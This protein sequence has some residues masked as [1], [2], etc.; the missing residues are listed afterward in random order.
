[1]LNRIGCADL[2]IF[3]RIRYNFDLSPKETGSMKFI[4]HSR[5]QLILLYKRIKRFIQ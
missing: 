2:F 3:L 5:Y 1:M 4:K